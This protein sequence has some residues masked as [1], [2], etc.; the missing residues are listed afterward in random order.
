MLGRVMLGAVIAGVG[1][2]EEN[3]VMAVVGGLIIAGSAIPTWYRARIDR[4]KHGQSTPAA[5][6]RITDRIAEFMRQQ[7]A[8]M[9]RLEQMYSEQMADLEERVDFAER[10]LTKQ[11]AQPP[12][13]R[14]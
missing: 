12:P 7:Q 14:E 2:D 9:D 8:Q 1:G 5:E 11:S 13:S 4:L 10:L 3:S 6:V